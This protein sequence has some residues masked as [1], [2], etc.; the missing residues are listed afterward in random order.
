MNLE[1]ELQKLQK[2]LGRLNAAIS[3][4]EKV[5]SPS[6]PKRPCGR[7]S[8]GQ[9]E[10]ATVTARMHKYWAERPRTEETPKVG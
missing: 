3:S 5:M 6:T 2:E 4:L 7:K 9:E 10:S 1:K 8:M